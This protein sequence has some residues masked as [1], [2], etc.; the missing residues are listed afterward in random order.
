VKP[1]PFHKD[2]Q[3][4]ALTGQVSHREIGVILD[5]AQAVRD[6]VAKA[7]RFGRSANTRSKIE[8]GLRACLA[9]GA[10][11]H[12]RTHRES[13]PLSVPEHK[14]W[15]REV[16][17]DLMEETKAQRLTKRQSGYDG[18]FTA[19]AKA[20]D[21]ALQTGW[22]FA[23]GII[24]ITAPLPENRGETSGLSIPERYKH[25]FMMMCLM[26]ARAEIDGAACFIRQVSPMPGRKA[27]GH[28]FID[29]V[30][31]PI[32]QRKAP[33]ESQKAFSEGCLKAFLSRGLTMCTDWE[34]GFRYVYLH[35]SAYLLYIDLII[36][37]HHRS[38]A[39][40]QSPEGRARRD[41]FRPAMAALHG[42]I[43]SSTEE[44]IE[45]SARE[46]KS[47]FELAMKALRLH[48]ARIQRIR[49]GG[50]D[51]DA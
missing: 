7:A 44:A 27:V 22:L 8:T 37:D 30:D 51:L 39:Y 47:E 38:V 48:V 17:A 50:T 40:M 18:L 41:A 4:K 11:L 35:E 43:V 46:E 12:A 23:A 49:S 25:E 42:T 15:I 28:M 21:R 1:W 9:A 13:R 20:M 3:T 6:G 19:T 5:A 45:E 36:G 32:E 34:D 31:I 33:L 2:A 10:G 26:A 29:P 24:E 14:D 16:S